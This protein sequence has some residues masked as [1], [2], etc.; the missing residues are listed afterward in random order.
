MYT[1][2]LMPYAPTGSP[3]QTDLISGRLCTCFA[4]KG[5]VAEISMIEKRQVPMR[6]IPNIRTEYMRTQSR[7]F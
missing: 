1:Y 4:G 3:C 5:V 6:L 2:L 7:A